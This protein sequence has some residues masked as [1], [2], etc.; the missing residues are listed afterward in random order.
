MSP[1]PIFLEIELREHDKFAEFGLV[2]SADW[3]SEK[4]PKKRIRVSKRGFRLSLGGG[5]DLA[6][7]ISGASLVF[8]NTSY[9][10]TKC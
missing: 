2:G 10:I 4:L 7:E 8:S 6:K 3:K 5:H 9:G 1:S